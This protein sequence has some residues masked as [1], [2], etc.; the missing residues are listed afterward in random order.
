MAT[1]LLG[2]V[3]SAIGA[4]IG[5]S[6]LG[7]GAA[8]IGRAVGAAVGNL[9]DQSVIAMIRS[10]EQQFGPE[11]GGVN[12][13]LPREGDMLARGAGW[14]K[15]PARICWPEF[16]HFSEESETVSNGGKGAQNKSSVTTYYAEVTIAV[17]I[18]DGET[19]LIGRTWADGSLVN[20]DDLCSSVTIYKG[21]ATQDPD[22]TLEAV[23]GAGN[24]PDWRGVTYMVL[25]GFN[26][27]TFG[28]RIPQLE[29]ETF[30]STSAA[31]K[32]F[33]GVSLMPTA[34]EFGLDP[35]RVT[36]RVTETVEEVGGP[37]EVVIDDSPI[38]NHVVANE[39][40]INAALD[41]LALQ[42]PQI[43]KVSIEYPWYGDDLRCGSCEI[44]P[45]VE[46]AT[47]ETSPDNWTVEGIARGSATI[48]SQI[49]GEGAFAGTP[50]DA[51]VIRLIAE[52]KARGYRVTFSPRILMDI[53]TGNALVDPYGGAEQS[54]YPDRGRITCSPAPGEVGTVDKTATAS[55]QVD[56][57][58]GTAVAAD[59][60]VAGEVVSYSG[61]ADWGYNRFVLHCAALV[62][63]GGGLEH[64]LIGSGLTGLMTLRSAADTFPAVAKMITLLGEVRTALLGVS[65]GE[66]PIT[67][68][69]GAAPDGVNL[70]YKDNSSLVAS[71]LWHGSNASFNTYSR[72]ADFTENGMLFEV[73]ND[74]YLLEHASGTWQYAFVDLP[75]PDGN[76]AVDVTFD[77]GRA[78]G[79]YA[80]NRGWALK[81]L[82][83]GVSLGADITGA[84][85]VTYYAVSGAV[86]WTSEGYSGIV[87]DSADYLRF[88]YYMGEPVYLMRDL[89][90]VLTTLISLGYAADLSEV[91][92]YIPDDGTGDVLFPLDPLWA[93]I[94]CDFIGINYQ[95][96]LADFRDG[97]DGSIYDLGDLKA[98]IESG[99]D[100]DWKYTSE[101]DR[102][103][104]IRTDIEDLVHG[105]PW[106]F[107]RKDVYGWW[108]NNHHARPLGIRDAG[109]SAWVASSKPIQLF[110]G[111]PA[112]DRAANQPS[113]E[114]NPNSGGYELPH[115]SNGAR[116][117][118]AQATY[119]AAIAEFW[120]ADGRGMVDAGNSCAVGWDARP[121]PVF[122]HTDFW[123]DARAWP[124][125]LWLNGRGAVD[126]AAWLADEL[127]YRGLDYE[128]DQ[129]TGSIDGITVN[130]LAGFM[131]VAGPV[132]GLFHLDA[133][134]IDGRI[135]I[136]SR[137]VQVPTDTINL[138]KVIPLSGRDRY[139]V[140]RGNHGT[141]PAIAHLAHR[142]IGHDYDRNTVNSRLNIQGNGES[143]SDIPV[144]IDPQKAA[145]LIRAKH[146]DGV[147]SQDS[148][149]C[150]LPPSWLPKLQP[151]RAIIA[152]T[153]VGAQEWI[154]LKR[155]IGAGIGVSARRLDRGALRPNP[156]SR[157]GYP[158]PRASSYG[159]TAMALADLPWVSSSNPAHDMR[160]AIWVDP[161]QGSALM[162]S[163]SEST[164][165]ST[166]GLYATRA[167]MGVLTAD[168]GAGTIY[169][170]DRGNTVSLRL[171]S[172]SMITRP[173][174]DVRAGKN[175]LAVRTDAA[176]NTWELLAF[177]D[178]SLTGSDAYDL[179]HLLRGLR[180]SQVAASVGAGALVVVLEDLPFAG[181]EIDNIGTPFWWAAGPSSKA[182]TDDSWVARQ[183][184]PR[185]V[186]LKPFA[187]ARLAGEI[188]AGDL[189]LSWARQDR[190]PRAEQLDRASIPMSEDTLLFEVTIKG[191]TTQTETEGA[192]ILAADLPP[193]M[194][195][196]E[197]K[198]ISGDVGA[199][200]S[201]FVIIGEP[202]FSDKW[203]VYITLSGWL[204]DPSFSEVEM[205]EVIGG[206]NACIGGT[207]SASSYGDVST[208]A[209]EAFDNDTAT[210]WQS[211]G[212]DMDDGSAWLQYDF[213]APVAVVELEVAARSG[214]F[215][216]QT[217]KDFELQ[218]WDGAQW[219]T[220]IEVTSATSW[221]SLE[222]RAYSYI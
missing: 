118:E 206:A 174:L 209:A 59:F 155:S 8:V 153:G 177:R 100:Y 28:D 213:A 75:L 79:T 38:N 65:A 197:V 97:D 207:A 154:M 116:D 178:A 186:G 35:E 157:I 48:V 95:P 51:G 172:G 107:R 135:K 162:R 166:V 37:E 60:S 161:A 22:P 148:F 215:S 210:L 88:Q 61:P 179:T 212:T 170:W 164:G 145:D 121:W 171:F 143:Y 62:K 42:H 211:D 11:V 17:A 39:A 219:V 205:R 142:D 114:T 134:E 5:G 41:L 78:P 56:A 18:R 27:S 111:C 69:A 201:S 105:E 80:G 150:E 98:A 120:A 64:F 221:D 63:A 9:I 14:Q 110:Y 82:I 151:G 184:T 220:T 123:P 128:L 29:F 34:G 21:S 15:L 1:I 119:V 46:V 6:V 138:G 204:G 81:P 101:A 49:G 189:V 130:N 127:D 24:V 217:P 146:L 52:L 10:D 16:L 168:L 87:R 188:V 131:A 93:D 129:I 90:V 126:L 85:T 203:R 26:L 222:R 54:A 102:Q 183:V 214:I 199:G 33:K 55:T 133:F 136:T 92:A 167:T 202:V 122:P 13:A 192:V 23:D 163:L 7:I 125:G 208:T 70:P 106:V 31:P 176:A 72:H 109:A 67:L 84:K 140:E 117:D 32:T 124:T 194:F 20:L 156:T 147:V 158:A 36:E 132:L 83:D 187:P 2:A 57:F 113:V 45:R 53:P 149:E 73:G 191:E 58:Y 94:D 77:H 181:L 40:D 112:I 196:V 66:A 115:F 30:T 159:V 169:G 104:R 74:G 195:Q 218:Y 68:T 108:A 86:P 173:E 182:R 165:F 160:A 200:Y 3:G 185:G 71:E 99:E 91:G 25:E 198:Q 190:D 47:R 193:G 103:A 89:K 144:A 216:N 4:S 141:L 43:E 12:L 96:P 175:W 180:G 76:Y 137:S 152:D 50:S 19:D 44:R 139:R